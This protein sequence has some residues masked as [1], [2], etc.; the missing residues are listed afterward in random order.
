MCLILFAHQIHPDF[1][2]VLAANRDEFHARPTAAAAPWPEAPWVLG[3]RDLLAGGTWLAICQAGRW[4]AVTNFREGASAARGERS[5]GHLVSD[6]VTD[7]ST[8]ADYLDTALG[9][10]DRYAG[11]NLLVGDGVEVFW[12]SN[13]RQGPP[14][15]RS[16]PPGIYG[17]SNH[18]LDTPWPK[19]RR[20]KAELAKLLRPPPGAGPDPDRLLDLLMDRT[21]AAEQEL[22]STG[23]TAELE[24]ALSAA[25]IQTSDYGTRSS[26]ALLRHRNG[27]VL[28][29]ERQFD[30][31]GRT[32]GESRFEGGA[33]EGWSIR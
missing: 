31:T 28:F 2:L 18:L 12:T 26:T 8:P 10:E 4:A 24:R 27:T 9:D 7:A 3:G 23:V 15:Y 33:G 32:S 16:L 1:P 19:V 30:S 11:Y 21:L 5:R 25:F 29:A 14:R 17:V 22:P 6:Y 13:R 20:G